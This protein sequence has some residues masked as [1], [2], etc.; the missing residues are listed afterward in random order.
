MEGGANMSNE[1]NNAEIE[2]SIMTA[3][4]TVYRLTCDDPVEP[5][6]FRETY[7]EYGPKFHEL[8]FGSKSI[9]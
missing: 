5:K 2:S 7:L 1:L 8:I 9:Q 4:Y 3:A 6:V